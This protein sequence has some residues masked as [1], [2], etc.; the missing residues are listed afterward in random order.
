MAQQIKRRRQM[1]KA[2]I[3]AVLLLTTPAFAGPK[4]DAVAHLE[5][6]ITNLKAKQTKLGN[7]FKRLSD[8]ITNF[9]NAQAQVKDEF[10]KTVGAV[11][12]LYELIKKLKGEEQEPEV[13]EDAA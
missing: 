4:E 10:V 2:I 8:Q 7:D 11:D 9:R 1:K 5:E 3:I 6:R 13:K 12:E